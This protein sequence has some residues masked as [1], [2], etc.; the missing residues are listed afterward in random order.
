MSHITKFNFNNCA[1]GY[2][3]S[4]LNCYRSSN[5]KFIVSKLDGD[6]MEHIGQYISSTWF[7]LELTKKD[8]NREK[9]YFCLVDLG[10]KKRIEVYLDMN[11]LDS[12]CKNKIDDMVIDF[13]TSDRFLVKL[14]YDID[15]N[16]NSCADYL[17]ITLKINI[18]I[19][20]DGNYNICA[21]HPMFRLF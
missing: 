18:M 12:I 13:K 3:D 10:T 17:D 2:F 6:F 15:E 14:K 21:T 19:T 9:M 4:K 5:K 1:F 16:G 7:N 11:D 20:D 8:F